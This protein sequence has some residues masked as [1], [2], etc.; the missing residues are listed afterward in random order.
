MDFDG[1]YAI[2]G[3]DVVSEDFSGQ[4]VMLNLANGHYF[5]LAGIAAPIWALLLAGHRPIA[6]LESIKA[7]RPE[8]V[9]RSAI[10]LG[11]LVELNLVR[12]D[13][14]DGGAAEAPI[15]ELW[16]GDAP[17]IE[18]YD[19]LAELISSDP[20]HDVDEQAGWPTPRRQP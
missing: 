18:V 20:I 15:A 4:T 5:S 14:A 6:I 11:R 9:D 16:T 17:E 10:F 13:G 12:L 7:R 19:D 2:N 3:P 1:R 8:L